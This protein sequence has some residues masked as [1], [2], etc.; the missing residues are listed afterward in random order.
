MLIFLLTK[1]PDE[2]L[3]NLNRIWMIALRCYFKIFSILPDMGKKLLTVFAALYGIRPFLYLLYKCNMYDGGF[4][5]LGTAFR[6]CKIL[7]F[8]AGQI[9]SEETTPKSNRRLHMALG[10]NISF[11]AEASSSKFFSIILINHNHQ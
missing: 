6:N 11:M 1:L 9:F 10:K 3:I 5:G 4:S 7:L 2:K 8:S